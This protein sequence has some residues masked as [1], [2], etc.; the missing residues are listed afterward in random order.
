MYIFIGTVH[1][2]KY[3]LL[4][5]N[6]KSVWMSKADVL[7]A[8]SRCKTCKCLSNKVQH[9]VLYSWCQDFQLIMSKCIF[10]NQD[11]LCSLHILGILERERMG[12]KSGF[13]LL[14]LWA[15]V[16]VCFFFLFPHL[17]E[18]SLLLFLKVCWI[19]S[20]LHVN[21]WFGSPVWFGHVSLMLEYSTE[22]SHTLN[23]LRQ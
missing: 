5:K 8:W 15:V 10:T 13:L 20:P 12:H 1:Q 11:P 22:G 2:A 14:V 16:F 9:L 6:W 23:T 7:L 4:Y 21:G 19:R 3:K 18:V 17:Y